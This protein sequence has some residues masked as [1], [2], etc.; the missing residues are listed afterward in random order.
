MSLSSDPQEFLW[1]TK[2]RPKTV[3]ETILPSVVKQQFEGFVSAGEI[4]N[5]ILTGPSGVGKTTVAKALCEQMGKQFLFINGSLNGGIDTLR[6]EIEQFVNTV[7]FG[8]GHKVVVLD[9]VDGSSPALQQALRAFTEDFSKNA[10]FILTANAKNKITDAIQSRCTCIDFVI[11]SGEKVKLLKEFLE[12]VEG[13]LT[14]EGVEYDMKPL[15]TFI[16]Q[17]FPDMRKVLSELQRWS[18]S[19]K[20]SVNVLASTASEDD[21]D[22]L[23]DALKAKKWDAM[24]TWVAEHSDIDSTALL[25]AFYR[26]TKKKV[27]MS[28]IPQIV[29]DMA[30]SLYHLQ[31]CPDHEIELVAFFTKVMSSASFK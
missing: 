3:A 5:L 7:S 16:A 21:L 13:I 14:A 28:S 26:A 24:R 17:R 29:I 18:L 12:R 19:G 27:V 31:F 9:E 2:Y 10:S 30:D 8:N 1:A 20:I 4:P 25:Q 6:V 22:G 11:P 15:A 23:F